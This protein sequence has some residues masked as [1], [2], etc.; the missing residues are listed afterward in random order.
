MKQIYLT[1]VAKYEK[2]SNLLN[3]AMKF[4]STCVCV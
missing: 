4:E 1:G 2:S 3:D